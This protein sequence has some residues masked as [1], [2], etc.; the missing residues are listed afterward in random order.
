MLFGI[1][2]FNAAGYEIYFTADARSKPLTFH[3]S[4]KDTRTIRQL[5]KPYSFSY[6]T[7]LGVRLTI[8]TISSVFRNDSP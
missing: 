8:L 5:D 1:I 7:M 6:A 3:E 4:Q 2:P